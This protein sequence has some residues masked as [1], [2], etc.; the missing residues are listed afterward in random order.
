MAIIMMG[1]VFTTGCFDDGDEVDL[2]DMDEHVNLDPVDQTGA[3]EFFSNERYVFGLEEITPADFKGDIPGWFS[4]ASERGIGVIGIDLMD[5]EAG[6]IA[7]NTSSL[8]YC[9]FKLDDEYGDIYPEILKEGKKNNISVIIMIESA[10]H[11]VEDFF[12]Y[13]DDISQGK[14]V[15]KTIK[16]WIRDISAAAAESGMK[17]GV[18]EEAFPPKYMDAIAEACNDFGVTYIHFFEDLDGRAD[19]Y[20]SEDYAYY[21]MDAREDQADIDYML[22][23]TELGAYYGLLGHLNIMFGSASY[24]NAESG[25]LTAGGWGL[26]PKTH[27]NIALMRAIQFSPRFY[28]FV[29]ATG[30]DGLIFQDEPDY[31]NNYDFDDELLPLLES[32]GRKENDAVKPVAN[33]ILD[34]PPLDTDND[35]FFFQGLLSSVCSITNAM[36]AA[37]YDIIVTKSEPYADADLYYVF[38]DGMAWDSGDDLPAELADLVDGNKPVY[39]QVAGSLGK[40]TN[41][42][43]VTDKLGISGSKC[44]GSETDKSTHEK[45]PLT[46]KYAFP[47]GISEINYAGYSMEVWFN[48]IAGK[49]TYSHYV[50]MIDPDAY[51]GEVILKGMASKDKDKAYDD[52][53][54]L[55][56][57]KDNVYFVNSG[58]LHLGAS[59]VLANEMAGREVYNAPSYGYLT[60]CKDRA[61]FFAPYDTTIDI[62]LEAGLDNLTVFSSDGTVKDTHGLT[63]VNGTLSG[64]I[65]RFEMAVAI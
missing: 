48:D 62:N 12:D 54:G 46:A 65:G 21:P 27:Q 55:I 20:L 36:L 56:V 11:I 38:T 41:W 43:K 44:I 57:K 4:S 5:I 31:V 8:F 13:S 28:F 23:L 52:P 24:Q 60:A 25:V 39:Y 30:D 53:T 49:Q 50:H 32:Y 40:K 3:R 18:T 16:G 37:G 47:D 17:V 29:V 61:V 26:G 7:M 10:A 35:D 19:M 58:Y 42:K 15:P 2:S 34:K 64:N 63:L 9:G 33:L 51:E 1:V 45:I 6:T 22:E 14:L 59:P